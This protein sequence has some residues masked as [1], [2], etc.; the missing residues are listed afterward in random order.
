MCY[1]VTCATCGKTTWDG[2]GQH[3]EDVRR[4]VPAAEWCP[5]HDAGGTAQ[6]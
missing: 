5:G 3:V 6:P 2:C 1:P 4:V